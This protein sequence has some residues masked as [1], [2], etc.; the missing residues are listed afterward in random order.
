MTTVSVVIPCYRYGHFLRQCVESVL[1]QEG[2][3]AQILIIDDASPDDSAKVAWQLASEDPRVAFHAHE[4]NRGHIA[5]Y[6]EGIEWATG[7]YF[8][9]LSADDYLLPGALKRGTDLLNCHADAVFAFG[10]VI[11]LSGQISVRM[12]LQLDGLIL[13][14]EDARIL[15]GSEFI[16]A[17]GAHNAVPTPTA[18]VRTVI[19]KRLGGYRPELPHAGDMEMWFRLA[20]EGSVG[21]LGACQ[22][23]YRRHGSNMSPDS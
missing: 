5:T 18:I 2:I 15:T 17:S 6:N 14:N 12:E 20:S 9:L 7:E 8:L 22:A 1:S 16:R 4:V 21:V 19:Q 13:G 3:D 23:V 10:R 11:E